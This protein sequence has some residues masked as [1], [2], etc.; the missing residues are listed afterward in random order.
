VSSGFSGV[1]LVAKDGHVVLKKGYG[2]A[3]RGTHAAMTGNSVVQ[4]G[5]NTKDFTIVSIL[6]LQER[7]RL[8]LDDSIAKYFGQVPPDKRGI[9]IRDLLFHRGGF[10]QHLGGDWEVVSR[11]EEIAHALSSPL[12]FTPETDRS[13]PTSATV[14]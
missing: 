13:T 5:S 4:I 9:T 14:S 11:E 2:L 6:Q 8:T 1:A 12:L 7:G 10:D 3:N